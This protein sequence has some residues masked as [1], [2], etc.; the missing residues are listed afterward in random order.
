M[1]ELRGPDLRF[2][3][4]E[5][6]GLLRASGISVSDTAVAA[7]HERTEGWPAGVRLAA[8][9]L[10]SHPDPERFVSEFSGS[11]RTVAGYLLAE[12]LERQP[13]EVRDLLIPDIARRTLR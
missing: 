1:T 8:I 13:P 12:V 7:L 9:S 6:R 11:E 5:T 10:G 4:D 3:L 2:A